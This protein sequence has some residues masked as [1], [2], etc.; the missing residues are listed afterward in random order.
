ML[1]YQ[2]NNTGGIL[3]QLAQVFRVDK[4]SA[5]CFIE[6]R[7]KIIT[8]SS[9]KPR[10]FVNIFFKGTFA[11]YFAA[12]KLADKINKTLVQNENNGSGTVF[13]SLKLPDSSLFLA[14]IPDQAFHQVA[15]NKNSAFAIC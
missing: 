6:D 12:R 5:S 1:E 4:N 8:H 13:T 11:V 10:H 2:S 3:R 9:D 14:Q 15:Q 7:E